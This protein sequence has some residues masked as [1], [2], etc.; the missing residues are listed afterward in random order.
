MFVTVNPARLASMPHAKPVGPA[1]TTTTS[2]E[3]RSPESGS[4][5]LGYREREH[6]KLSAQLPLWFSGAG[7]CMLLGTPILFSSSRGGHDSHQARRF[8]PKRGGRFAVHLV[9]PP[10]RLHPEPRT[11]L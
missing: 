5:G 9:L 8:R 1:P 10:G 3:G 11:R 7:F 2:K 4:I 6:T